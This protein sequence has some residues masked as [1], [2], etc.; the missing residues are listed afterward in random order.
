[1]SGV[2]PIAISRSALDIEWQRLQ[3]V[4]QNLANQSTSRTSTGGPYRAKRLISGPSGDFSRLVAPGSHM[5][6][7]GGVRVVTVEAAANVRRVYD[8]AHP[9]A[10]ASGFVALPMVDHA[11][12][13]ALLVKTARV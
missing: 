11:A 6:A 5:A 8:P 10:D 4:A 3:L 12:E 2:D 9:D 13:M 7:P 1:M